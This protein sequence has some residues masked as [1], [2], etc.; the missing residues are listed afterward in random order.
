M[1]SPDVRQGRALQANA[2]S[3]NELLDETIGVWQPF[4]AQPLSRD[5][6]EILVNVTGFFRI[7]REWADED[8]QAGGSVG[9]ADLRAMSGPT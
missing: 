8:R 2:A 4:S 6:R 3:R 9:P 1:T 7:L 5:A